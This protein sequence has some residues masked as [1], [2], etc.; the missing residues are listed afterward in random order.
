VQ[1]YFKLHNIHL[2]E[3]DYPH[4]PF[5]YPDNN[6]T[7]P[8]DSVMIL[9]THGKGYHLERNWTQELL[10]NLIKTL[11]DYKNIYIIH[12]DNYDIDP[13]YIQNKFP[14]KNIIVLSKM[15]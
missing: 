9:P 10:Y 7:E 1:N 12:K 15:E 2:T 6:L 11:P 5:I 8:K 13:Y 3:A 4:V 14:N